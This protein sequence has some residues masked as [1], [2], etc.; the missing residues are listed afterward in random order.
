MAKS[1]YY[2]IL[3]KIGIAKFIAARASGNGINLKSFKLSSKVILPSEE[4]QSLEEIVY[5]ANISSKS[6]DESNPNYVNL[7]CHVPSD[8]GGFEVN[9]VG[10]YDEAGDL[11]AVGNVPR[12]YKPIL[13]EGSAKELMIKIV[14]ELSNAEEVILK[15]DP[16][17][18]MASRDYVDAIKVELNLKIDAL[19]Q[20]YDAEFKK[21]W[22]EFAKYLL[23]NKFNTEIAKYVTLATNQTITGAKDFTKLPT[24]SI[25]ATNDNQFVNLATLKENQLNLK[26]PELLALIGFNTYLD[27]TSLLKS[28][29]MSN[30]VIYTNT[31]GG[32]TPIAIKIQQIDNVVNQASISI[33]I[34][35]SLIKKINA[36]QYTNS[37]GKYIPL[38]HYEG[39]LKPNDT[40]KIEL[41]NIII[42]KSN[43]EATILNVR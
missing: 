34:N 31:T 29:S 5:E 37:T 30:N 41:F 3:T 35:N 15:L 2:T 16:S 28:H 24:S 25:K 8:V 12:T 13:K 32:K 11:L 17:V 9:A 18:I 36:I 6:V 20:K 21:V 7:M 23:E 43:I 14:M 39:I 1:E 10:V 27:G 42:D 19:T 38:T 33:Y 4:M 22:D 26:D 40:Y